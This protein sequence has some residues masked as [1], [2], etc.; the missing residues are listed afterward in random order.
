MRDA[1]A[2]LNNIFKEYL[3]KVCISSSLQNFTKEVIYNTFKF[4]NLEY[5]KQIYIFL[6]KNSISE[7]LGHLLLIKQSFRYGCDPVDTLFILQSSCKITS[8]STS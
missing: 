5:A 8:Q 2:A 4:Y 6:K 3:C 1:L 7:S